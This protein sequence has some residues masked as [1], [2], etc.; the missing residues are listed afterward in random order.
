MSVGDLRANYRRRL[1]MSRL[2][3]GPG[4][5]LLVATTMVVQAVLLPHS[6]AAQ[7]VS[8]TIAGSVADPQG[9][10][11]PGA[12]LTVIN[13]ATNDSRVTVS[14]G[15]GGFQV[16]NLQPGSYTVKVEM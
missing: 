1:L 13:E 3:A 14:D 15:S 4:K 16:T 9:Q 6:S 8:G 10:V 2:P 11:L 7:A 5:A 12:T